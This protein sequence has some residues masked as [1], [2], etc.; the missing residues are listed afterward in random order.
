MPAMLAHQFCVSTREHLIAVLQDTANSRAGILTE[1]LWNALKRTVDME[2][3]LSVRFAEFCHS[4]VIYYPEDREGETS[5]YKSPQ[6]R[7]KEKYEE[8]KSDSRIYNF[9]RLIS[10]VFQNHMQG[11]LQ[12]ERQNLGSLLQRID[13]EEEWT[14]AA[15]AEIERDAQLDGSTQ[16]L[17]AI[18]RSIERI[19]R[20]DTGRTFLG[21]F[22]E[23]RSALDLYAEMLLRKCPQ[24]Q[25]SVSQGQILGYV[26][27]D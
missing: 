10:P 14:P 1:H 5:D 16:L 22:L 25:R 17:I 9:K 15:D 11:Y 20:V 13:R 19:T 18:R 24:D 21:C 26:S 4:S 3:E 7:I 2:R 8:K 12:T 27:P 23:Y 6:D